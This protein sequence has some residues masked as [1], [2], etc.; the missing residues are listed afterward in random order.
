MSSI[1]KKSI[2]NLNLP[3]EIEYAILNL[4][5]EELLKSQQDFF[6]FLT[7]RKNDNLITSLESDDIN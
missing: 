7:N 5:D 1:V 3:Y 2:L 4:E 6:C